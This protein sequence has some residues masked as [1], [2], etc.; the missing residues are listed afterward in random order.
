ME[1]AE[2]EVEYNRVLDDAPGL[3]DA[4]LAAEI[5]QLRRLA[6][7]LGD[8]VDRRDANSA[9]EALAGVLAV[10]WPPAASA[11]EIEAERVHAI[12]NADGGTAH[13]RIARAGAG[14]AEI[15]RLAATA[16]P[17]DKAGILELN[18]S[19]VLLIQALE[20]LR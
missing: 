2:F 16:D 15:S 18:E 11:V 14:M 9:V 6:A 5:N 3:S 10:G 4:A 1:Y 17:A 7:Q 8:V 13:E 19:L 12:A 20:P